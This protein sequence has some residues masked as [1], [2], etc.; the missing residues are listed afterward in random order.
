MFQVISSK[1]FQGRNGWEGK[2]HTNTDA[3]GHMW[4]ITTYKGLKGLTCSA[5]QGTDS[6][7]G[8]Y[9]FDIFGCKK[10]DLGSYEGRATEKAVRDLHAAGLEEFARQIANTQPTAP[11]YVVGVGQIIFTDNI[12]SLEDSR[13][14]VYEVVRPGY[15]KTVSLNG[16]ELTTDTRVKPYSEKFGIGAYYNE[17]ETMSAEEVAKLVEAAT[18]YQRAKRER[19]EAAAIAAEQ[20][21]KE[22]IEQG[23]AIIAAIPTGA[24]SI[25]V[26]EQRQDESDSQSD[27]FS[28]ST[29][30][31][32]YLAF[33]TH[34]RDLFPEMRK[35]AGRCNVEA[36][37]R[38][39]VAPV[40]PS[41]AGDFWQ[42]K[43]EHREK[44]SM[45]AGYYLGDSKYSG[46]I[47]RK[48]TIPTDEKQ[49]A[50]FL[51]NLQ[52]AAAEGLFFAS[53]EIETESASIEPVEVQEGKVKVIKYSEKALAVV[54]DTYPIKDKLRELGGKFNK[55]LSCGPG[56]I[57]PATAADKLREAFSNQPAE[58]TA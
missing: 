43:D 6:G 21:R 14:V 28:Y 7:N 4:Q 25:I 56:W 26:A 2:A 58:V 30:Q 47:I 54:G 45:G 5:M 11:A 36:V 8:S 32:I 17:G 29:K 33:S 22:K 13:R 9:S 23:R 55:F 19:E 20:A 50:A 18:D 42:P 49:R 31:V 35:A 46:W 16:Q 38:Y 37:K 1:V 57:F 52:V 44:Y 48:N 10:M 12:H 53:S 40:K 15:F 39:E 41:D 27:Y 24:H 34:G 51:E 3:N